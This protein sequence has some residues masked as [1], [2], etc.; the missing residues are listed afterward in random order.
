MHSATGNSDFRAGFIFWQA[1]KPTW[2]ALSIART[3]PEN[4]QANMV[5]SAE[6]EAVPQDSVQVI[7]A[8]KNYSTSLPK[9]STAA[10]IQRC[11]SASVQHCAV[12]H[13]Q[14]GVMGIIILRHERQTAP[15][16]TSRRSCLNERSSCCGFPGHAA[17]VPT[18]SKRF[19]KPPGSGMSGRGATPS[20]FGWCCPTIVLR[21]QRW[22]DLV[23]DDE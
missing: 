8:G 17:R 12:I 14:V 15:R 5:Y 21:V 7:C 9:R 18:S 4:R 11:I 6:K 13:L 2:I 19:T 20:S 10:T 23:W 16:S 3:M 22:P 1:V